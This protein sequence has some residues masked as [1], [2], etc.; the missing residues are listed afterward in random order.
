MLRAR[1]LPTLPA[2]AA[3][4]ALAALA[5]CGPPP[6]TA[7]PGSGTAPLS[8]AAD[9]RLITIPAGT[10]IAG[11]TPEERAAAYDDYKAAAGH[12]AAREHRWFEREADRHQATLPAFRIDFMPVTQVQY[13]EYVASGQ[14]PPPA[15]DEAAW[16]AQGFAQDYATQVAR[17]V[18][19]GGRAPA[20]RE[21]H[22][23]VLV[24]WDEA[25]RYCEWRG[26]E[27][28]EPRRLPTAAEY[29]KAARGETGLVYPWG[30]AF[31]ADKLNSAAAGPG[32]T[33]PVG[34]YPAGASPYGVLELAGNVFQWTSTKQAGGK[35]AVKGSAWEDHAGIGRGASLHGRAPGV[36][37]VIV[38]FR[39]AA[40][41]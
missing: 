8:L 17:D 36:R 1:S 3:V 7:P 9:A 20:G 26:R 15:I 5:A 2:V 24:T 34:A 19:Q 41:A 6:A 33:T 23:V 29:E 39:C 38:G 21:E 35:Q 28:G 16:Q 40:D 14:A 10:Y 30:N 4:A 13:A 31:E 12:D 25:R 27:R 18:W 11:S 37:H 32:D 22:P